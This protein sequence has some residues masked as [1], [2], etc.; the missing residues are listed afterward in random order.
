MHVIGAHWHLC[1]INELVVSQYPRVSRHS[2]YL[3]TSG[4]VIE[5]GSRHSIVSI[6]RANR[7][8]SVN[9]LLARSCRLVLGKLRLV[10]SA[11]GLRLAATVIL[12][13]DW[14]VGGAVAVTAYCLAP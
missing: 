6:L 4:L 3:L 13:V 2:S 9:N 11:T 10:L 12:I 7:V 5:L 14:L 8:I 1:S